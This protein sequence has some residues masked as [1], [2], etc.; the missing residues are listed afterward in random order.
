MEYP[1]LPFF[2]RPPTVLNRSV[3]PGNR[4][5]SKIYTRPGPSR[6]FQDSHP[7]SSVR[8]VR[9]QIHAAP[10]LLMILNE[11]KNL[12]GRQLPNM[13]LPYITRLVFD[14]NAES[15]VIFHNGVVS[16]AISSRLFI[17]QR[18]IEIVFFAVEMAQQDQGYGR[19]AMSFLKTVIQSRGIY[20]VLTCADNDAVGF[21]KK[22]GFN[23]QEIRMDP[24]RWVGYIKDYDGV[25]LMHCLVHPSIDYLTFVDAVLGKQLRALEVKTG[26][27][28]AK[29]IREF[30][31]DIPSLP[32][33]VYHL[34][35]PLHVILERC[36]PNLRSKGV[37]TLLANY[38]AECRA[39]REKL[40]RILNALK[41]DARNAE[42][43][44]RPV[45]EDVAPD[46]FEIIVSPM[47]LWSIENRLK[48]YEDYYKRPE[49]FA[50]DVHLMCENAKTFNGPD[51][52]FYRNAVELYR[53][54]KK[55]YFEEFPNTALPE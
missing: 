22:Q 43:F 32:H 15:I 36:A 6:G 33:A 17:S 49:I 35:L 45:T 23:D 37:M 55:L 31:L 3:H 24:D 13:G 50:V 5:Q 54:F 44:L 21:F 25:T 39:I 19:L 46:Y 48:R 20:D 28:I 53:K 30:E 16:G 9:N 12:F 11:V 26:L 29:P 27:R 40:F 47:D 1:H 8:V 34:S 4:H 38:V 51:S 10:Q 41:S 2:N 7:K 14:F 18:F 52:V 42:I